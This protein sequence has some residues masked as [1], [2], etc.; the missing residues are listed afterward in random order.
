MLNAINAE[1]TMSLM[2]EMTDILIQGRSSWYSAAFASF[3]VQDL[4]R[5][6]TCLSTKDPVGVLSVSMVL[7]KD[8]S[9]RTLALVD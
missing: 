2:R 7:S 4:A 1:L 5:W 6:R 8:D 3:A 9:L